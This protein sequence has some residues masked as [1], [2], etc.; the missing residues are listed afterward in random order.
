[1]PPCGAAEVALYHPQLWELPQF[2]HALF[3]VFLVTSSLFGLTLFLLAVTDDGLE[4]GY[5][6]DDADDSPDAQ[7]N[8]DD[9][10]LD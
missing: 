4:Q 3:V 1:M 9:Q 7:E 6:Q 5:H 2:A 10:V 8:G